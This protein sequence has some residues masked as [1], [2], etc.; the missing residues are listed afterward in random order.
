MQEAGAATTIYRLSQ[1]MGEKPGADIRAAITV[2][3][4][5]AI[6]DDWPAMD[7]GVPSATAAARKAL[8]AIYAR[9]C[10]P[11]SPELAAIR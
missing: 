10:N 8:D 3:L 1:G 11:T 7:R 2:Y 5:A 9:C 4:Q 6:A